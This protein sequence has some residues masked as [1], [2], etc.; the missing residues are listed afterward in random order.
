MKNNT[1]L[2]RKILEKSEALISV[3]EIENFILK[4]RVKLQEEIKKLKS[5]L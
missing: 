5:Q 2:Y 1:E 3:L 4:K